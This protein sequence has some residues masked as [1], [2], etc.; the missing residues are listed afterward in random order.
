MFL[1]VQDGIRVILALMKEVGDDDIVS[2]LEVKNHI[3][4]YQDGAVAESCER[5]ETREAVLHRFASQ[6][7]DDVFPFGQEGCCGAGSKV[8]QVFCSR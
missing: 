6:A 2:F 1:C 8:E 3:A 5:L 4:L 7:L